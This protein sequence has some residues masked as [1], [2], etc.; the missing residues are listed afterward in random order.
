MIFGNV[1]VRMKPDP[2]HPTKTSV[3]NTNLTS[4]Y[5][6]V[7]VLEDSMRLLF[8][9]DKREFATC[10]EH[11]CLFVRKVR[12]NETFEEP[13]PKVKVEIV[14]VPEPTPKGKGK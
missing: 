13:I 4:E 14:D 8:I 3:P 6:V 7:G 10:N 5:L 12:E 1:T 9:N 11:Q 2:Q